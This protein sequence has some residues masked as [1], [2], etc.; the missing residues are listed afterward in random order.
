MNKNHILRFASGTIK[1]AMVL[2]LVAFAATIGIWIHWYLNSS[3]Y[4]AVYLEN[5]FKAGLNTFTLILSKSNL[6]NISL[7]SLS[8]FNMSWLIFRSLI[9]MVIGL[10]ALRLLLHIIKS[11]KD[12]ETFYEQNVYS[13]NKLVQLGV[14]ATAIAFFNFEVLDNRTNWHFTIP[15]EPLFATVTCLVL[16]EVFKEGMRL[17]EDSKSIV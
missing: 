5:G 7:G 6:T 1:G 14:I 9:L 13:F 3:F 11:I 8:T 12:L 15:F 2:L 10:Y 4:D 16:R 17:Q